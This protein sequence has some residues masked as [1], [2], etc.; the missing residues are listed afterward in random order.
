MPGFY[1]TCGASLQGQESKPRSAIKRPA[2]QNAQAPPAQKKTKFGELLGHT[3]PQVYI[4]CFNLLT[5]IHA[6]DVCINCSK[7]F[8]FFLRLLG[9]RVTT[10]VR[11]WSF[12]SGEASVCM[13]STS[14]EAFAAEGTL[15]RQ[16]AKKLGIKGKKRKAAPVPEQDA[17]EELDT[18]FA[19]PH[20]PGWCT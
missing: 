14:K 12:S 5:F 9:M 20:Y 1:T 19:G 6:G 11:V 2:E 8:V 10:E 3:G 13:Q 7:V 15:Q 4:M 18:M 16:L 17:V